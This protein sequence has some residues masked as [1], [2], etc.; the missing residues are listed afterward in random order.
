M[1]HTIFYKGKLKETCTPDDVFSKVVHFIKPKGVTKAWSYVKDE[2]EGHKRL[3][4]DFGDN[5]SEN[6]VFCF[7]NSEIE[8]FC[9]TNFYHSDSPNDKVAANLANKQFEVV[10]NIFYSIRILFSK[11]EV[12]DDFEVWNDFFASK[13]ANE[14]VFRELDDKETA[15]VSELYNNGHCNPCDLMLGIIGRDLGGKQGDDLY[16]YIKADYCPFGKIYN[17]LIEYS[18]ASTWLHET[19]C[20]TKTNARINL[21]YPATNDSASACAFVIAELLGAEPHPRSGG[22]FYKISQ[23]M[24]FYDEQYLP[25]L[26]EESDNYKKCV[27]AYRFIMSLLDFA[28]LKYVGIEK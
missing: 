13:Q 14:P 26:K 15:K 11:Y 10:L 22:G 24:K 23:M 2:W 9:K 21:P 3:V 4:I 6:L 16:D 5:K 20:V 25:L 8:G 27:L 12:S 19:M 17:D 1:A 18:I 28:E 7:P